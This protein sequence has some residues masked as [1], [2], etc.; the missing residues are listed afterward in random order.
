MLPLAGGCAAIAVGP[1]AGGEGAAGAAGPA[2]KLPTI[3][4][5]VRGLE[6]RPGLLDLWV[7]ADRGRVWLEVPAAGPGA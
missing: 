4:E 7:D 3:A 6:H 2:G 1:Q 5:T